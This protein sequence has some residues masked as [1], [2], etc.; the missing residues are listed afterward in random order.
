MKPNI[1]IREATLYDIAS[2]IK[3][4]QQLFTLESDFEVN[5]DKQKQ[6]LE[7]LI[8]A[9]I[10]GRALLLV[11]EQSSNI[12]GMCSCQALLSTAEGGKVGLVEDVIVEQEF[13]G[14]GVGK[15]LLQHLTEWASRQGMTRL[16]LLADNS[17]RDALDFYRHNN[18]QSTQLV[19][20]R[21]SI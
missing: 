8:M 1:E 16:Q 4:L 2:L 6:G 19:V 18:W 7:K 11:A 21:R 14:Q 17:N 10:Q 12:I 20:M 5:A 13:R 15:A 3:L 9:Q